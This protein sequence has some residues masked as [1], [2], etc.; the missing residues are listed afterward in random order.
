MPLADLEPDQLPLAV[1]DVGLL[2]AVHDK[3]AVDEAPAVITVGL[4]LSVTIGTASTVSVA[5]LTPLD[6]ALLLQFKL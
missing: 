6:P 1:Q 2:V 4:T 3:V 5:V